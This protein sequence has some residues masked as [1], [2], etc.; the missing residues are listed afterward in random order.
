[1]RRFLLTVLT[2]PTTVQAMVSVKAHVRA[3]RLVIDE[4]VDLPDGTE[5][6]LVPVPSDD[7]D[8]ESRAALDAAL[9]RSAEQ[10]AR[11]D[12]VDASEVLEKLGPTRS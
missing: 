11:G 8:A 7:L 9:A 12:T 1:M 2:P 5:I 4:V 10:I 6:E 3:G